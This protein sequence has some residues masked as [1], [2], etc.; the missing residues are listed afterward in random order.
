MRIARRRERKTTPSPTNEE[1]HPGTTHA[2]NSLHKESDR[3]NALPA[4]LPRATC[5]TFTVIDRR[6]GSRGLVNPS[7]RDV[8]SPASCGAILL[9]LLLRRAPRSLPSV[10]VVGG[11]G[12][13]R[14]RA[15]LQAVVRVDAVVAIAR[16]LVP[17]AAENVIHRRRHHPREDRSRRNVIHRRRARPPRRVRDCRALGLRGRASVV[18]SATPCAFGARRVERARVE[19]PVE[20]AIAVQPRRVPERRVARVRGIRAEARVRG[21]PRAL[22]SMTSSERSRSARSKSAD[23]AEKDDARARE[24]SSSSSNRSSSSSNRSSS[25]SN[26]SSSSSN[27]SRCRPL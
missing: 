10:A 26:R 24:R 7:G 27:R 15:R 8:S 14:Q 11:A 9:V 17:R 25:S 6:S 12:S 5:A 23:D 21:Q 3:R 13:S 2:I 1:S 22:A 20:S 19:S 16:G 4:C 18:T